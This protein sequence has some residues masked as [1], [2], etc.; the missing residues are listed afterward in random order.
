M[1]N[2]YKYIYHSLHTFDASKVNENLLETFLV[3][4]RKF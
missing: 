4:Y 1:N 2:K 3:G